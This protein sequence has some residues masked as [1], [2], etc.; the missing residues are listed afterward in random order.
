MLNP[1]SAITAD[2]VTVQVRIDALLGE[3]ASTVARFGAATD[4]GRIAAQTILAE[5]GCTR[6]RRRT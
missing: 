3:L 1:V 6:P 5:I 4:V 2:I